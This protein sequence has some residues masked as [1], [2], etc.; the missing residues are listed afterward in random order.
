M[1]KCHYDIHINKQ[2]QYQNMVV[3]LTTHK[4]NTKHTRDANYTTT[5]MCNW[6]LDDGS[7][8]HGRRTRL[9]GM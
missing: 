8:C 1:S 9:A 4:V 2:P 3:V 7:K 6:S 5:H